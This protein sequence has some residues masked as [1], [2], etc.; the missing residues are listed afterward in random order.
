M[1]A[2]CPGVFQAGDSVIVVEMDEIFVWRVGEWLNSAT[3]K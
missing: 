1:A 2:P 3:K